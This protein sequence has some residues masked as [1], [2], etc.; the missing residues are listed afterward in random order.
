MAY[1]KK[2]TRPGAYRRK[3][4][5]KQKPGR[6]KQDYQTPKVLLDAVRRFLRITDD[7]WI[8]LAA[9]K[10]NR[11]VRRY[12]GVHQ[13]ALA[14]DVPWTARWFPVDPWDDDDDCRPATLDDWAWLNPPFSKIGPWVRKAH[15]E[16]LRG[17]RIVMLVPAAVGANW[18]RDWVHEKAHILLLNGRVTFV[19]AD[20]GYPKDCAILLYGYRPSD[21]DGWAP[22]YRVWSWQKQEA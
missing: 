2:A 15:E 4:M 21:A 5:P 12:Y 20:Q 19:G 16:S 3:V 13:N 17:G 7:F 10:K 22:W 1:W 6:S 14:S 8:D 18:W 9:T 11:V